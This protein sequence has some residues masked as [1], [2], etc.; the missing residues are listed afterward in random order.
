MDGKGYIFFMERKESTLYLPPCPYTVRSSASNIFD[1]KAL[2]AKLNYLRGMGG[3]CVAKCQ[4]VEAL[5]SRE[6]VNVT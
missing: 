1:V 2:L 4:R 3:G 6:D 5:Q